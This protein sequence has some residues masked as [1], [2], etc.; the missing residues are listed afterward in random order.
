MPIT[1]YQKIMGGLSDHVFSSVNLTKHAQKRCRQ[2]NIPLEE[3]QKKNPAP[4]VIR[5]GRTIITTYYDDSKPKIL[6]SK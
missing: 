3:L 6:I 1:E 5:N 2:R 4:V